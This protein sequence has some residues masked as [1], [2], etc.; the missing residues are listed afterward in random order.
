MRNLAPGVPRYVWIVV[1]LAVVGVACM[2]LFDWNWLRGPISSYLS[3]KFGRPVAIHGNLRGEFSLEPLLVADDV[4]V[5]NTSWGTD[6]WM[7]RA[8]QVAVRVQLLSLLRTVVSLPE[9]TLVRPVLRLERDMEGNANWDFGEVPAIPDISRLRIDAGVVQ[10]LDPTSGTDITVDIS[11]DP[12]TASGELPVQIKG[13][14]KLQKNDFTIEGRAGTLLALENA[15]RPYRIEIQTKAGAT[16]AKFDGTIVPARVENVDGS[17]TIQ[18]RDLAQLH[19]I[20]PVPFPWTPPY[21]LTGKLKHGSGVWSFREFSGK[22]GESDL[23]GRFDIELK[24]HRTLIDADL[25]SQKLNYKDLGGLIGLPP[26]T[27]APQARSAAQNKEVAKRERS[28]LVLPDKPFD[29]EGLRAVDGTVRFKGKHVLTTDVPLESLNAVMH[30]KEGLLKLQPFEARIAGG[31]VTS[32]LTMDLRGKVMK[33]DADVT[34][35]NV[36]LKQIVPA[37]RPPKGSAGTVGGRAKFTAS[38]NSVAEMLATSTG[39]VALIS[40]GGDASEL[41]IVLTNLDLARAVELVMRGDANS[42]IRCIVANLVSDNGVMDAKTLVIDTEAAKILGEG[43]IDFRNERYD[44][45]LKAQSKRPSLIA[46]R[47]PIAI[48]GSFRNPNVHPESAH[49]AAR[50]GTSIALGALNPLAALLPLVDFGGATDANCRALI[51]EA[52]ASV[53][54]KATTERGRAVRQP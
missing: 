21:R 14:G 2:A 3:G 53:Q 1:A 28:G 24:N 35:R 44:L 43:R 15:D 16:T 33:T 34:V 25:V 39:E 4:T 23:T 5:A 45:K 13:S 41:A 51:M 47:G 54:A 50:I 20:I 27:A 12:A 38:G 40:L 10:F 46:L 30:L 26:P 7:A 36:E 19:P 29:V 18:G 17:L 37:L 22:V 9:L 31:A 32:T 49:I 8:Q 52:S 6:P 42:P 48:D 11:S